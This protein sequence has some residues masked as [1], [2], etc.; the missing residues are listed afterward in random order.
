VCS[1]AIRSNALLIMKILQLCKKF[2]Y[3]LKDGESIAVTYLARALHELG[4]EIHLLA[5]NT[6]K[7]FFDLKKLPVEF[8]HYQS[9]KTVGLDN[10]LK[11]SSAL[12]NL[13]EGSS[14]HVSR[15]HFAAYE[16]ALIGLLKAQEFDIIQL[17]TLYLTP[18]IPTIRKYTTA[19]IVLRSHNIEHEIW[20]RVLDNVKNPL[21]KWY[22]AIQIKRLKDFELQQLDKV[23]LLLPITNRDAQ[24]Y[25]QLGNSSAV[26]TCPIGLDI[27]DYP[28][29]S[30]NT[31]EISLSFIGSLDWAPNIEGI[32]WFLDQVWADVLKKYPK[33][34]LHI[35][36]RNT[37]QWLIDQSYPNVTIHGEVESA[38]QFITQHPIMIVP[39]LS[40]G[41]MRVKILES[42][43]LSRITVTTSIGVE[44]IHAEDYKNVLIA[45]T[46]EEFI[47]KI[48]WVYQQQDALSDTGSNA[49]QLIEKQYDNLQIGKQLFTKYKEITR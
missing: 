28:E 17:E 26:L 38:I 15:Y 12:F 27:S 25:K 29:E 32:Q 34:E 11:A 41:G 35:A 7:H 31:E 20:E 6:T 21:K 2:P 16:K 14:Y 30:L 39:L 5:M 10:R 49:R 44:G 1:F 3:P 43:A 48:D 36:G 8:N 13:F 23:D 46:P 24:N 33:C 19:K 45:N 9:I 37:P 18:Y 22:L 40:G 42:M 4:A 47:N